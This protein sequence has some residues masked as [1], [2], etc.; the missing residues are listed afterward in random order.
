M[1][2]L[3]YS[4]VASLC[5]RSG[6]LKSTANL[7]QTQQEYCALKQMSALVKVTV[8]KQRRKANGCTEDKCR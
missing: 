3:R 2:V 5:R 7:E 4:C 6:I 8:Q 1:N